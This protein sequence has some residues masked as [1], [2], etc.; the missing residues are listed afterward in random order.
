[1]VRVPTEVGPVLLKTYS[2]QNRDPKSQPVLP[3]LCF[4]FIK[5]NAQ[6]N[7]SDEKAML[8]RVSLY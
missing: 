1:M 8:K 3:E 6:K 5:K 2:N 7:K 4:P